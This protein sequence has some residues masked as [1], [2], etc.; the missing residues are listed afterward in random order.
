[1]FIPRNLFVSLVLVSGSCT[2]LADTTLNREQINQQ[3]RELLQKAGIELLD[4]EVRIRSA[5]E[6][7]TNTKD[8]YYKSQIEKYLSMRAEQKQNG[9]VKNPEP[10]AKELMDFAKSAHYQ[11]QKYANNFSPK[12]THLRHEISE[13]NM[14]YTFVGVPVSEMNTNIGVAPFG[15]YKQTR[16]GDE[17]DGWDGAVQFFEKNGLGTCEFKEHNLKLAHGGVELVKEL[18]SDDVA[19]KP[20]VLL[21]K[22]TNESGYLYRVSWYDTTFARDLSCAAPKYSPATQRQVIELAKKIEAAQ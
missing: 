5:A 7:L 21:V 17:S 14:A 1:M 8:E 2:A 20:T 13:L 15:A 10:R 19:G 6:L 12:S 16:Y 18:V 4:G 9:F 3:D 22:G 11:Y